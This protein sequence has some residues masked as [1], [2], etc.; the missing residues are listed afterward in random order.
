MVP[1]PTNEV[2]KGQQVAQ[3]QKRAAEDQPRGRHH[4]CQPQDDGVGL[5]RRGRWGRWLELLLYH[6]QPHD[7]QPRQRQHDPEQSRGA[8]G[9][10]GPLGHVDPR[11]AQPAAISS[12]TTTT[13]TAAAPVTA[14]SLRSSRGS[15][16]GRARGPARGR[17]PGRR[18][19][20]QR[21]TQQLSTS[22]GD[23]APP[24]SE[25]GAL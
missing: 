11:G 18:A 21:S 16:R 1:E 9:H 25:A 10:A 2:Q 14:Q 6:N 3:H 7:D 8:R 24:S 22:R 12:T 19:R 20:G 23:A 4:H 5:F 17:Q 15:P 13:A